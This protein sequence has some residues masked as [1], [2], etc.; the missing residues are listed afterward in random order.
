MSQ[1]EPTDQEGPTA[2]DQ[3]NGKGADKP[4]PIPIREAV[5]GPDVKRDAPGSQA[6]GL[7]GQRE[8]PKGPGGK[9]PFRRTDR[10]GRVRPDRKSGVP[11]REIPNRPS[12]EPAGLEDL[13]TRSFEHDGSEWIARLCGQ[14]VS[15]SPQDRGA[16]L[17]HLMFYAAADP[18]VSCAEVLVPGASL[19]GLAEPRLSELLTEARS[20]PPPNESSR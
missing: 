12:L 6:P 14:T 7:R 13:P 2:P 1:D 18:L 8:R 15:G 11:D 19:E 4:K 5:G 9:G 17:M 16:P 3:P 20:M 10:D